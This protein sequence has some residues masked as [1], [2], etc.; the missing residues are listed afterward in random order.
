L[1][2]LKF[3]IPAAL[4]DELMAIFVRLSAPFQWDLLHGKEKLALLEAA[5]PEVLVLR[6]KLMRELEA[7][8]GR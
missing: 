4:H 6:A 7:K 5:Q 2:T 1:T 8:L 3:L